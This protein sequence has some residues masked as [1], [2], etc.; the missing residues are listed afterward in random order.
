MATQ[1]YIITPNDIQG[2]Q[3]PYLIDYI[4]KNKEDINSK[5]HS[6][7]AVLFRGFNVNQS[8]QFE[9]IAQTIDSDLKNDYLGTSPRNIV[10]GTQFVFS[11]SEL[12][13]HY[14]IMQHCEMSFLPSAPRRLMFFCHE[15]PTFGGETPI[16]DFRQ[17]A[18]NM[19]PKIKEEFSKK[20]IKVIRNYCA[21]GN[22]KKDS[23][24]LKPWT[25]MFQTTDKSIVEKKCT[26]NNITVE[27][28]KDDALRLTS[29]QDAFKTH[30]ITGETA[31]FNH[32]QVFHIVGASTEYAKIARRQK[33]AI[34]W[35]L[36]L[37]LQATTL[38][39]KITEK[40]EERAMHVCFADGSEIPTSY[41]QHVQDLI[42]DY[43]YFLKW[44]KG[45]IIVIDNFSTSHGRMP[46]KGPRKI[47]V[48]WTS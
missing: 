40:P 20:G 34:S 47:Y 24:Q 5:I 11:A 30:P 46:Y 43:M 2:H 14:P 1:P 12:P 10:E 21:P 42:W 16:C 6:H 41:I 39:K 22:E 37:Y 13:A 28:L 38:V 23:F 15:A 9:A 45:D 32:L 44:E 31:W 7:G 36:H 18:I 26:E 33:T 8:T 3:V 35:A 29:T 25:D 17:L 27:W 19:N 4:N 48:S